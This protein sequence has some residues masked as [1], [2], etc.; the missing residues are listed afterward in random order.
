MD[1]D[2]NSTYSECS[3]VIRQMATG[4]MNNIKPNYHELERM[5]YLLTKFSSKELSTVE[6][7]YSN[8]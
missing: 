2:V 4:L 1:L 3:T 8:I 7:S 5:E 6:Y